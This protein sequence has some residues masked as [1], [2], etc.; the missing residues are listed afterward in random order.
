MTEP[1]VN[2]K[3]SHYCGNIGAQDIEKPVTVMGWVH[4][5]RDHGGV[6]FVDLRDRTGL[7]QVAFN[8]EIS[9][10]AVEKAHQ[11]RSEDVIAV[12]GVV[13]HR[14]DGTVNT[15]LATG[16]VEIIASELVILN[17]SQTPPFEISE[18]TGVS[19]GVSLKYRYLDLR[20]P[21]V[22]KTFI[23]RHKMCQ[24]IRNTLSSN[25]FIEIE[26]PFLTKSTPEGARDYLVPSRIEPGCFYA[27]PQS[28]QLFKQILMISG[29]D[30]YFQI[31]KCFRDE[32]LR[33]DRQPE[34]TQVDMELSFIQEED[35]YE[36]LENLVGLL[37]SE[38]LDINIDTPFPRITYHE[39]LNRFG[40][41][42]PAIRFDLELKDITEEVKNSSFKVFSSAV[43][44]NGSVKGLNVKAKAGFS[45][46][47]L[48]DITEIAKIHGAGGLV[49]IKITP[50]GWQSPVAKFLSDDEKNHI[51]EVMDADTGDLLL[52]VADSDFNTVCSA[53][54]NVR[55]HIIKKLDLKPSEEFKF[56]WITKFPLL[57]YSKEEKRW[58]AM[59]HPFTSPVEEDLPLL[60]SDP[61][62]ISARAYDLVLNGSEI[63]GGSI[64]IHQQ[65]I[66]SKIFQLLG[67]SREEAS[68]KFG[69]LLE[70]LK[71]GAPPHGGIAL[72]L[73]RLVMI[74][75][76]KESIRDVIAFPKTQ[77]AS[78]L[79][80]QAPS[81]VSAPQLRELHI[82][83]TGIKK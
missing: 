41:D 69:F 8:P 50:E 18:R 52:F 31:V 47:E 6:I 43:A 15:E 62:N 80:S 61:G 2:L 27:L 28:P 78:C 68:V 53:L 49:W 29:F 81:T 71:F 9:K 17:K 10:M 42:S 39:A 36:T 48:D 58:T 33:A 57:E 3:R 79:M 72:G 11:L 19:E 40:L 4:K 65:D 45:R 38:I 21:S 76:G 54:G 23:T 35:I 34:F 56:C 77:K 14:P 60:D 7:L 44:A 1:F 64:R 37:F 13:C 30:R 25:D 16:E 59:H 74:M 75:T 55:L 20:R 46:K 83:T 26:T 70:A 12:K 5:R 73:D 51:A 67:I 24:I 82:K 66:Q 22:Q 32:D 63:G